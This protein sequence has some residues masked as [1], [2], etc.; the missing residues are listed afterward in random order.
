MLQV[1][2]ARSLSVKLKMQCFCAHVLPVLLFGSETWALTQKLA[3]KLEVVHSDCLRHILGVRRVDRHSKPR[4]WSHC[5]AVSL[6]THLTA[7]RLPWLGHVLRMGGER[8]PHLALFSF[9][10]DAWLAPVGASPLSWR[11]GVTWTLHAPGQPTTCCMAC[12]I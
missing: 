10:H 2:G 11:K 3:D 12:T 7:D 4:L 8:Y 5:D 9:M 1:W 6:A